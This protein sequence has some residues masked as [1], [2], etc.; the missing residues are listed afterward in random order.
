VQPPP[1][2]VRPSPNRRYCFLLVSCHFHT[3]LFL[4]ALSVP[5]LRS[6]HQCAPQRFMPDG[7]FSLAD[8]TTGVLPVTTCRTQRTMIHLPDLSLALRKTRRH[9]RPLELFSHSC[10]SPLSQSCKRL[11]I[12]TIFSRTSLVSI[13]S[14]RS[15]KPN[16]LITPGK[17][18]TLADPRFQRARKLP[19]VP[20][21]H[22]SSR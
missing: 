16:T 18:M 15:Q 10:Q 6:T 2:C 12:I 8:M 9:A 21:G 5:A 17:E 7:Y 4:P 3:A 22:G 1:V 14:S 13:Y 19:P 20:D 11:L